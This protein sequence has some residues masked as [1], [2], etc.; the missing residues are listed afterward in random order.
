MTTLTLKVPRDLAQK[1]EAISARKRISK[2]KII[3]DALDTAFRR[4][5]N[6]SNLYDSMKDGL[7]CINSGKRDLATNPKHLK[8]FG[9]WRK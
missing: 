4:E 2:S 1:L 5:K 6:R 8:G 7:G 9:Q 3:R